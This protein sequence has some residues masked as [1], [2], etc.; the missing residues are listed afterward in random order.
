MR[1]RPIAWPP[2]GF[3]GQAPSTPP[4]AVVY[5]GPVPPGC[6]VLPS[7]GSWPACYP[8]LSIPAQSYAAMQP[9]GESMRPAGAAAPGA[10]PDDGTS[11]V[12]GGLLGFGAGLLVGWGVV[13]GLTL[14]RS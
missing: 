6:R 9:P 3:L 1:N 5:P 13:R 2:P 7:Y 10:V 4:P 12:L 14:R 8:Y 11:S